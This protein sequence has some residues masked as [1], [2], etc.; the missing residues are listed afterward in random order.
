MTILQLATALLMSV[1]NTDAILTAATRQQAI[2]VATQ[3]IQLT[4]Q[5]LQNN[6]QQSAPSNAMPSSVIP[7]VSLVVG[8][9]PDN[10]VAAPLI[11]GGSADAGGEAR[12]PVL[13][14]D[15][16]A[17]AAG[18][19]T[20]SAISFHKVGVLSDGAITNA[21]L[22]Q[23]GKVL[24]QYDSLD[25][26]ILSFSGMSLSIPAGQTVELT[27]AIDIAGGLNAGNTIMFSLDSSSDI[28]AFDADDNAITPS[29]NFPLSGNKFT[30]ATV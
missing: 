11:S 26:G 7:S 30:V 1:Q 2:T 23:D 6:R 16:T 12:A 24:C 28:T 17:G 9:A 22:I 20:V 4:K 18:D 13:S 5:I 10:P 25:Q 21:Y 14:L 29:G 8:L 3:A 15:F 27:L 19:I